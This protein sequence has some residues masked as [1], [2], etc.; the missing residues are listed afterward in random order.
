VQ[1]DKLVKVRPGR[2]MGNDIII[3]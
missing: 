2:W 3:S 1:Q